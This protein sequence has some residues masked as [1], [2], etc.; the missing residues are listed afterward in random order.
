MPRDDFSPRAH[1]ALRWCDLHGQVEGWY[2]ADRQWWGLEPTTPAVDRL[3]RNRHVIRQEVAALR[4]RLG[5]EG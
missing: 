5:G 3:F 1:S 4:A 2:P